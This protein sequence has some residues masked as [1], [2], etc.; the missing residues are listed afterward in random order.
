MSL[1]ISNAFIQTIP[2]RAIGMALGYC[3]Y[4]RAAQI[5]NTRSPTVPTKYL[6]YMGLVAGALAITQQALVI[7]AV[8]I[9]VLI[10]LKHAMVKEQSIAETSPFL[11][12]M[13]VTVGSKDSH[14]VPLERETR[15]IAIFINILE[16]R[17]VMITGPSG[18]GKTALLESIVQ[19]ICKCD[20]TLHKGLRGK[21]FYRV[22]CVSLMSGAIYRG[23]L[24]QRIKGILDFAKSQKNSVIVFDEIHQL[25]MANK[26]YTGGSNVS[27]LDFFKA[28]L[29]RGDIS[30]IG[31]TTNEEFLAYLND[32]ALQRRFNRI[33]LKQ[34]VFKDSL[35]MLKERAKSLL[36]KYPSITIADDVYEE[37]LILVQ[38][39]VY[40]NSSLIDQGY[41]LLKAAFT[42]IALEKDSI[43]K[44]CIG[45]DEMR[46]IF[47]DCFSMQTD[48][49]EASSSHSCSGTED[50]DKNSSFCVLKK[51]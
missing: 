47:K 10:P 38:K 11:E 25:A 49:Q 7:Y 43:D 9:L 51:N 39:R 42:T 44:I 20:P 31:I 27:A 41:D 1:V 21:K 35:E 12:D 45:K 34:P 18:S 24:E 5:I 50:H 29:A 3:A 33:E 22:S 17:N 14:Y 4:E 46:K 2:V 19:R 30:V 15:Q 36:E 32:P 6:P 16:K 40:Q 13:D 48:N 37:I 26:G 28:D 23:D 8:A